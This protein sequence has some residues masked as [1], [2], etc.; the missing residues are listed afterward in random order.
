[1]SF[2]IYQA[3]GLKCIQWFTTTDALVASMLAHPNDVYH[4]NS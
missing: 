3:D 4:R 1:M 2:T